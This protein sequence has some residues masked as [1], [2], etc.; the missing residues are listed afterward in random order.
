MEPIKGSRRILSRP[1][2]LNEINQLPAGLLELAKQYLPDNQPVK[3]I[4]V[5]PPD[6][7]PRGS[8]RRILSL[9]ALIFTHQGILHLAGPDRTG[10]GGSGIWLAGEDI[11]MIKLSLILL[12]GKLEIWGARQEQILKIE[13]E[14]NTVAH[15]LLDPFLRNLIRSTWQSNQPGEANYHQNETFDELKTI[16]Y[17]F[18]NGLVNEAIQPGEMILG[19]I[20]QAELRKQWMK[21]FYRKVFPQTVITRTDQQIILLQ[22]DLKFRTHHEWIF[23]FIPLY[24]ISRIDREE[25]QDMMKI[26]IHLLPEFSQEKMELLL[27]FQSARKLDDICQGMTNALRG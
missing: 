5:I 24:R 2:L 7:I 27:D 25:F 1:Y 6:S 3:G 16:S 11:L 20:H 10:R 9:E 8:R 26:T 19:Y 15:R 4:F 13:A 23:T 17:S 22:E 14:Y 18:Y 12:Y 21:I